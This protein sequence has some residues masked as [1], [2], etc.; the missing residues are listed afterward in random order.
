MENIT[1]ILVDGGFYRKRAAV[2]F[3]TKTA[4]ERAKELEKY[5]YCHIRDGGRKNAKRFLYRIFYYDCPPLA[6]TVFHPL[7]QQN[8]NLAKSDTYKWT[9]AFFKA[10]LKKRKVALR[11]GRLSEMRHAYTLRPAM[12]KK[13]CAKTITIDDLTE[14]DFDFE[15]KQKGV[16]M[17]L[18]LDIAHLAYKRLVNQIVLITGDS[19]FVPAAKLARREGVDFI[20]DPMNSDI[21]DDLL[22]HVDG[23]YSHW[24]DA[25][26]TRVSTTPSKPSKT[27]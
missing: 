21:A 14:A 18:G 23:L 12:I 24:N 13:L 3:G 15:I 17:K 27:V 22:A 20:V 25:R 11:L 1:A 8:V 4:E 19:D 16:D 7:R 26:M 9:D 5:C 2:L 10:L 6:K